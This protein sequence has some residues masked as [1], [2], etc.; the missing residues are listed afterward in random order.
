[1]GVQFTKTEEDRVGR[2]ELKQNEKKL[3]EMETHFR[4]SILPYRKVQEFDSI[5]SAINL[6]P[7]GQ[8]NSLRNLK[9]IDS[10]HRK[11]KPLQMSDSK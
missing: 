6:Q 8:R 3:N 5:G 1:M 9:D 4:S 2:D 10:T 7:I 11:D